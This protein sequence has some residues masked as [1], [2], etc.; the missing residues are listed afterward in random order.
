[1]IIEG[2]VKIGSN[3]TIGAS[4]ILKNVTIG[5]NVSILPFSSIEETVLEDGVQIGPFALC[6]KNTFIA[7]NAQLGC[8]VQ[9]KS[10][11]IG[12]NSKAK[13]LSYLGNLTVQNNCNIGAGFIHCNYDGRKKHTST[14]GEN[15]FVGANSEVVGPVDIQKNASVAAGATITKTVPES[16]LAISRVPQKN[17]VNWM[18]RKKGIEKE[19]ITKKA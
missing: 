19:K 15:S 7:E 14:I 18:K 11:K 3:C 6:G 16:A 2:T 10:T 4:C 8:F 9:T 17:I 5:D 1:M 12:K 13:H